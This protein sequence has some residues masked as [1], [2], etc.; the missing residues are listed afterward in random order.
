MAN[1]KWRNRHMS[2]IKSLKTQGPLRHHL[3]RRWHLRSAMWLRMMLYLP[4]QLYPSIITTLFNVVKI[5]VLPN[6]ICFQVGWMGSTQKEVL[7]FQAWK[8]LIRMIHVLPAYKRF[9]LIQWLHT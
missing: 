1:K 5:E 4:I 2:P 3:A 7:P 9:S 8:A 6:A